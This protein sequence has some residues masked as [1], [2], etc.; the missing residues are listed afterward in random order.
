MAGADQHDRA[1]LPQDQQERRPT[2]YPL[3][4]MLRIHLL[5]QWY[6]LSDPAMEE[7]FIVVTTMRKF[8]DID[9]I[10][11]QI[12][13]ETTILT[14]QPLLKEHCLGGQIFETVDAHLNAW[15]MTMRLGAIVDRHLDHRPQ[16]HQE[17]EGEALPRDAPYQEG[18]AVVFRH[19]N[20]LRR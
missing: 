17:Q 4:V 3:A 20:P 19:E 13:D 1:A 16:L 11:D 2:P 15:H 8:A 9:L 10:S 14:F 12:P 5:K 7:A 6:L 18:K